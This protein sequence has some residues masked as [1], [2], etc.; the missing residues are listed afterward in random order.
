[1][2]LMSSYVAGNEGDLTS[3]KSIEVKEKD[4]VESLQKQMT[5]LGDKFG[6]VEVTNHRFLPKLPAAVAAGVVKW[7]LNEAEGQNGFQ[8]IDLWK[9]SEGFRNDVSTRLTMLRQIQAGLEKA[10]KDYVLGAKEIEI[11]YNEL[12]KLAILMRVNGVQ[13]SPFIMAWDAL[14]ESAKEALDRGTDLF[15]WIAIGAAVLFGGWIIVKLNEKPTTV[16][17]NKE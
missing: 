5:E 1:M 7:W 13:T 6:T 14:K 11:G 2:D 10:P 3:K 16:V 9:A 8:T 15:R 17:V 12:S 4:A